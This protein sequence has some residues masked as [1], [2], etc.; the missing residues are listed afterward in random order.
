MDVGLDNVFDLPPIAGCCLKIVIDIALG[1]DNGCDALRSNHVG[2]VGQATQIE[3]LNLYRFQLA[4][5][6]GCA[7][8][9]R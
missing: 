7:T 6:C 9:R 2:G 5:Y 8:T 3:S 1:I 4:V